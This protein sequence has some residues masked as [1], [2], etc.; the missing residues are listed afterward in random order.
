VARDASRLF[1]IWLAALA[2]GAVVLTVLYLVAMFLL[3]WLLF[4]AGIGPD[5]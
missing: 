2:S 4:P 1:F 5:D 3:A